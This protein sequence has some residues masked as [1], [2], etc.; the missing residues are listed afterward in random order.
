MKNG[1]K[2]FAVQQAGR[3]AEIYIYGDIC[4]YPY[5]SNDVSAQSIAQQIKE[6]DVE[7][8]RVYIDSYG[9][10]VS[11]GWAI[12]NTLVEHPA[13]V[14]TYGMGFV[15]SAALY[16]F[17][18][19]DERY[20]ARV[21][22]YYLH[23]I[24]TSG[25]GYAEELRKKADE[26]EA[27]TAVGTAA[28]IERTSMGKEEVQAMMKEETWL[29]PEQALEKGIAT[30]LMPSPQMVGAAQSVREKLVQMIFCGAEEKP[31]PKSSPQKTT[32]A[33]EPGENVDTLTKNGDVGIMQMLATLKF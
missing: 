4:K 10:D 33:Q 15:A 25:Y 7:E 13:K 28:F 29:T 23:E 2:F 5:D 6:L 30:A 27:L 32:L 8:I 31:Q 9:G 14:V 12:Y 19:G 22:A 11:E 1:M 3:T 16:P 26:A 18:A 21:S 20:A 17:L 24:M